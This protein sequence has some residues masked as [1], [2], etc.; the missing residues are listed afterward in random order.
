M[1][2][3]WMMLLKPVIA[4]SFFTL[5]IAPITWAAWKLIPDGPLKWKLFDSTLLERH[6]WK[7]TCGI[8]LFYV[9]FFA[10]MSLYFNP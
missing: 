3:F 9:V 7:T 6:R 8:I 1:D 4:I 2:A 5:I 10:C